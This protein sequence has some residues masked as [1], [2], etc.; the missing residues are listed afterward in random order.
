[1]SGKN[2]CLIGIKVPKDDIGSLLFSYFNKNAYQ[3]LSFPLW[4]FIFGVLTQTR[5]RPHQALRSYT[6]ARFYIKSNFAMPSLLFIIFGQ[7]QEPS[8]KHPDEADHIHNTGS[9]TKRSLLFRFKNSPRS[10]QRDNS[11]IGNG[12]SHDESILAGESG[13][14]SRHMPASATSDIAAPLIASNKH[15]EGGSKESLDAP[16]G[17]LSWARHF[18]SVFEHRNKA[19]SRHRRRRRSIG[20]SF[21]ARKTKFSRLSSNSQGSSPIHS[22]NCVE[23][24]VLL[25]SDSGLADD[26]DS[27]SDTPTP[28]N[29]CSNAS[30]TRKII[31][32]KS[33]VRR[34]I[35]AWWKLWAQSEQDSGGRIG[36]LGS[37]S[38]EENSSKSIQF[39]DL[40]PHLK[41]HLEDELETETNAFQTETF[42][43]P[44]D[45]TDDS[46][47]V[48][49]VE[50]PSD[51]EQDEATIALNMSLR[52]ARSNAT[53]NVAR[54]AFTEKFSG[55]KTSGT[56]E[57]YSTNVGDL[58]S[59]QDL[60]IQ[61]YSRSGPSS[62]GLRPVPFSHAIS[63]EPRAGGVTQKGC[64]CNLV[65]LGSSNPAVPDNGPLLH[66]RTLQENVGLRDLK[67]TQSSKKNGNFGDSIRA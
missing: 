47:S 38:L 13:I 24:G 7:K 14:K 23:S 28:Q 37:S 17:Y 35:R 31:G 43:E 12:I 21:S 9:M 4:G 53:L 19:T 63:F 10:L 61:P 26:Y 18:A 33:G 11:S 52:L 41:T 65:V 22:G 3:E 40:P 58:N 51:C 5:I 46:E 44:L 30:S 34:T 20:R 62:I 55:S 39:V 45:S 67:L 29:S 1:M 42:I 56:T 27:L 49:E 50:L 15:T 59:S 60:A 6:S 32:G 16:H 64:S 48:S 66:E 36:F 2:I 8:P 54:S 57:I 25:P